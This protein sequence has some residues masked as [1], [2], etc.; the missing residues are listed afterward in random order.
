[1]RDGNFQFET[2][3]AA[4][5]TVLWVAIVAVACLP[6]LASGAYVGFGLLQRWIAHQ[7]AAKQSLLLDLLSAPSLAG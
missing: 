1:M 2:R 4:R 3:P 5:L 7:S 6:L